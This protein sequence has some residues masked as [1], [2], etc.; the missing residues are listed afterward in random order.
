MECGFDK[1][2]L[3]GWLGDQLT[4]EERAKVEAHLES[5]ESCRQEL[6]TNQHLWA[7]MET[8]P[9]PE[10]P[11]GTL[12]KF[13]AMLDGF[14]AAEAGY[15]DSGVE[16]MEPARAHAQPAHAQPAYPQSGHAQPQTPGLIARLKQLFAIH[17]GF[18][19]AYSIL[20]VV[21]GVALGRVMN[22]PAPVAPSS[23]K[24]Q[25]DELAAQVSD[26]RDMMMKSL[27]QNPSASERIRGVSFT[28]ELT[29]VKPDV[30]DALLT[31][32]NNDPNVNVRLMT[33]EALTHYAFNPAVR[34]GLV[35]SI[36][37]QESPLV[38]AALADV[39]LKLQEKNAIRPFKKLLQQKDLNSLVRIKI[40]T[41]IARLS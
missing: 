25:L 37:G 21:I 17:P 31:T 30:I 9:A 23:D 1:T 4:P 11:A 26:M 36:S 41:A 24:K 5:C 10:P 34:A 33:L 13:N 19:M 18:A 38:Q 39:M 28:S 14:K 22:T 12:V 3:T 16:A 32:L 35:E 29:T 6:A 7:L 20:L 2:L 15:A 40:E 8:M 27:L